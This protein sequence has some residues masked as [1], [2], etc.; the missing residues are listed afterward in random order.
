MSVS[1][2]H[3]SENK[4]NCAGIDGGSLGWADGEE[5]NM[6]VGTSAAAKCNNSSTQV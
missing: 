3:D 5:I 2:V 6:E 1:N 4:S